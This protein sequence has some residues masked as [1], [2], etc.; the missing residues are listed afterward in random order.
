[1]WFLQD[2]IANK[3]KAGSDLDPGDLKPAWTPCYVASCTIIEN[4]LGNWIWDL[5]THTVSSECPNIFIKEKV[6][7]GKTATKSP[8]SVKFE[9][10]AIFKHVH[11]YFT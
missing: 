10:S 3:Y 1:M 11:Y 6:E 7:F 5:I 2:H 8:L 4:T 9:I